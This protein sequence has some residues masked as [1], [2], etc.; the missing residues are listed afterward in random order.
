MLLLNFFLLDY[1]ASSLSLESSNKKALFNI[2]SDK[3]KILAR[4]NHLLSLSYYNSKK[5]GLE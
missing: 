1:I 4:I 5:C 2:G 3:F